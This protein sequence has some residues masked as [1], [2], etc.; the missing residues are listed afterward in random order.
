M[1]FDSKKGVA[2]KCHFCYRRIDRGRDPPVWI[3]ALADTSI[4]IRSRDWSA[5]W[6]INVGGLG[7][8]GFW[9]LDNFSLINYKTAK[10]GK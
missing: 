3:G 9:T 4:L 1:Q 6:E 10:A 2:E 5:F 7:Y 8:H